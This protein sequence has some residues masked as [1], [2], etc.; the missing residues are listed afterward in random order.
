MEPSNISGNFPA[1]S[2]TSNDS[3]IGEQLRHQP[4]VTDVSFEMIVPLSRPHWNRTFA[5]PGDDFLLLQLN[6]A[7]PD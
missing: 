6:G 5:A 4:G 1:I 7:A 3:Y 2:L